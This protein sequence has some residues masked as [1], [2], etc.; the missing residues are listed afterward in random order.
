MIVIIL[1][2]SNAIVIHNFKPSFDMKIYIAKIH[3]MNVKLEMNGCKIDVTMANWN[4]N[5]F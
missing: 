5:L 3:K 4:L 1:L 2:F